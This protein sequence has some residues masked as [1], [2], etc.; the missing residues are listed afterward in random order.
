MLLLIAKTAEPGHLH[1]VSYHFI[2]LV[3]YFDSDEEKKP[4][5]VKDCLK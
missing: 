5:Q 1:K 4:L 2:S 3:F